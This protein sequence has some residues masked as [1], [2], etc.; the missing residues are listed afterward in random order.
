MPIAEFL[1]NIVSHLP[2]LHLL[3]LQVFNNIGTEHRRHVENADLQ[4]R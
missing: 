1:E 3:P 4:E 2:A